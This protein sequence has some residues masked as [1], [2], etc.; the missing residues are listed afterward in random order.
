M[1]VP[2]DVVL[3]LY[4]KLEYPRNIESHNIIYVK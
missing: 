2:E 1:V 4:R 3:N